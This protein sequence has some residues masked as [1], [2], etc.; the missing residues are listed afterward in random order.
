MPKRRRSRKL[1]PYQKIREN[2]PSRWI[3]T[4]SLQRYPIE[5]HPDFKSLD[6]Q[7]NNAIDIN[8]LIGFAVDWQYDFLKKTFPWDKPGITAVEID[9]K[10]IDRL[11][12][13]EQSGNP[14]REYVMVARQ[15]HKGRNVYV[16]MIGMGDHACLSGFFLPGVPDYFHRGM[17]FISEDANSFMNVLSYS[18]YPL[19]LIQQSLADDGIVIDVLSDS[20]SLT[21]QCHRTVSD[22][23]DVLKDEI[24][25]LPK[26]LIESV[27]DFSRLQRARVEKLN[28][29]NDVVKIW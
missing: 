11:Y 18:R 22:H 26:I 25:T 14:V 28:F 6:S 23:R 3:G 29:F 19:S 16:E 24:T 8:N 15:K 4:N 27:D 10:Q 12:Y 13:V 9:L 17:I 2:E 7:V 1:K 21:Y 5:T 20:C